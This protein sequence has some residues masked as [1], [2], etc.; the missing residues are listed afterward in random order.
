MS[1]RVLQVLGLAVAAGSA[2]SGARRDPPADPPA[3]ASAFVAH[4]IADL[5]APPLPESYRAGALNVNQEVITVED[6]LTPVLK[7]LG[8]DI[9]G[10]SPARAR[11]M[12]ERACRDE[13]IRQVQAALIYQEASKE[14]TDEIR[15]GV[16]Q[17]V[18]QELKDRVNREF[19]GRQSRL[20]AELAAEG[21]TLEGAREDQ[22]R[23][24]V[25]I[26]YLQD[27][28]LPKVADPTRRELLD[29]YQAHSDQY[30]AAARRELWLIDIPK[31]PSASQARAAIE[32]AAARLR[33]GAD[34]A[35]VAR[36][37]SRGLHAEDGG[38]WGF[39]QAPLQGRYRE[40]SAVFFTLTAD[41]VSDIIETEEA[42]FIVRA[43]QVFDRHIAG[44]ADVQAELRERYRSSQF[45]YHR[46]RLL[47]QLLDEA[48][49]EPAEGVFLAEVV[50]TAEERLVRPQGR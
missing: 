40:P 3:R 31:A 12:I 25:I 23:R 24:L 1:F 9:S 4:P 33:G 13:L 2:C 22:Q 26:K 38:A 37:F 49:I 41:Q 11:P 47:Q 32:Q 7:P 10:L 42:F 48:V 36:E 8:H 5:P 20:E 45:E 6:V 34:F 17:R 35:A 44:F 39:V 16:D 21:R 15:Q 30:T 28:I 19:G 50:R 46:V 18:D 43:G 27:H 29:Y 14:L